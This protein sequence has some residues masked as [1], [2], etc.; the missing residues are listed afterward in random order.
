MKELVID[1]TSYVAYENDE[2]NNKYDKQTEKITEETGV[3]VNN[4]P[5]IRNE[6][7][8]FVKGA[9]SPNPKGR[10]KG[11]VGFKTAIEQL[12]GKDKREIAL[13]LAEIAFYEQKKD[14][15]PKFKPTDMLKALELMLKYTQELPKQH[16]EVESKVLNVV[17]DLPDNIDIDVEDI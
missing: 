14:R 16:I 17:V 13:R 7:G 6:K 4:Q 11:S 1:S 2:P 5:I 10:P 12:V 9:P 3:V 15:W 8:H